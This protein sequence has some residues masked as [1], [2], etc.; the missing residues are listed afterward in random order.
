MKLDFGKHKG[1]LISECETKYLKWLASHESRLL[2]SHRWASRDAR[3]ELARREAQAKQ[4]VQA[5][6]Q[7]IKF[8]VNKFGI[9]DI[10]KA[11]NLSSNRGF[12]LLK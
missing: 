12:S 1:N 10:S 6:E 8:P 7:I 2:E 3:F 4:A 11:G 9:S 5:A